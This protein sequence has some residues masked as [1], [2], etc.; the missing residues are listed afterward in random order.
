M[1]ALTP[2]HRTL[3]SSPQARLLRE[4]DRAGPRYT[5]YPTVPQ[6]GPGDEGVWSHH[7]ADLRGEVALYVHVPFCREQCLYCGCN[8]VVARQQRAGDRFLD[9]LAGQL[10]TTSLSGVRVVAIHLGGGTPTWLSPDQLERL[11]GLLGAWAPLDPAGAWSVE[12]DPDVT[13]EG[14]LDRLQALGVQRISFGVQSLDPEVCAGVGRPQRPEQVR[15]R[16]SGARARGLSVNIDLMYGLPGQTTE[17]W[18]RTVD[19]VIAMQPDRVA[20]F[21]YAHVPWMKPHQNRMDLSRLPGSDLRLW[22]MLHA[23]E[24]FRTA[25]W[26]RIGFDH[27]ARPEDRLAVASREG[28]L[29]R[30]FMGFTDRPGTPLIGLG[31]S[32]ISELPGLYAQQDPHLG[33]WLASARRGQWPV[34]RAHE[35]TPHDRARRAIILSLTCRHEV[36]WREIVEEHGSA[37]VAAIREQARGLEPLAEAGLVEIEADGLSIPEPAQLLSRRVAMAFDGTLTDASA[38]HS[39]MV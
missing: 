3:L 4:H 16:V 36:R 14:H 38:R 31:P 35:L 19:G 25:G 12:A 32:A 30:D 1:N 34:T 29:Y 7:L 23:H 22:M 33:Q 28:R 8:M 11:W 2:A 27:F 6:W 15:D 9:A 26:E 24:R 37:T 18:E 21:G 20:V 5:S 17:T 13:S 10:A 39:R